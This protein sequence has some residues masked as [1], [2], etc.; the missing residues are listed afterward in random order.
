MACNFILVGLLLVSHRCKLY[1]MSI[2]CYYLNY[3]VH[4]LSVILVYGEWL[5]DTFLENKASLSNK[6]II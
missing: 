1:K 6:N 2:A 4:A 5:P 3:F